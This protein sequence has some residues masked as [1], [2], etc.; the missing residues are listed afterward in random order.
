MLS[1]SSF[2]SILA[3]AQWPIINPAPKETQH[4]KVLTTVDE[5]RYLTPDETGCPIHGALLR[6]GWESSAL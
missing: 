4:D 5:T 2:R 6:H 1:A 3:S